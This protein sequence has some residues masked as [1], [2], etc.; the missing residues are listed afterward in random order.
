MENKEVLSGKQVNI[1]SLEKQIIH[2]PN[3]P[4]G[5]LDNYEFKIQHNRSSRINVTF[6]F[7]SKDGHISQD[8]HQSDIENLIPFYIGSENM[9]EDKIY[10]KIELEGN[11]DPFIVISLSIRKLPLNLIV[12]GSK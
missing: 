5:N 6:R 4:M 10:T 1:N 8:Y 3:E 9:D 2:L 12:P 11:Y 7:V